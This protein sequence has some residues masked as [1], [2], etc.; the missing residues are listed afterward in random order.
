MVIDP[1]LQLSTRAFL[2]L[3]LL[4]NDNLYLALFIL[5]APRDALSRARRVAHN[6]HT[7]FSWLSA[8]QL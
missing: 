6:T 7:H 2:V 3:A 5:V 1:R 4:G 8:E